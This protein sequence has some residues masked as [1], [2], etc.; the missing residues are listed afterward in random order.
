MKNQNITFYT[1]TVALPDHCILACDVGGTNT[2]CALIEVNGTKQTLVFV[3]RVVTRDVVAFTDV[4]TQALTI[5]REKYNIVV[6]K[7]ACAVAGY[8]VK[9]MDLWRLT[10]VTWTVDK[11]EI[12]KKTMITDVAFLNDFEAI[13]YGLEILP[14]KDLLC[15]NQ[16][17]VNIH[18]PKVVLGAG[19]DLGKCI[20]AWDSISKRY[21]IA[22]SEGAHA[23]FPVYNQEELLLVTFLQKKFKNSMPIRYG[24]ILSGAGISNIY[25]FLEQNGTYASTEYSQ[26]I[27]EHDYDPAIISGYKDVDP[28]SKKTFELFSAF[29]GRSAKNFTVEARAFGGVYLAGGIAAKNTAI[30]ENGI[31]MAEFLNSADLKDLLAQTPIFIITNQDVGLY[32]SAHFAALNFMA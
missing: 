6:T 5:A 30:F 27:K 15:I 14:A 24:K 21:V 18:G 25:Q 1:K 8:P 7:A 26:T 17:T 16:G 22:P 23:D 32:G 3:L 4:I 28:C 29:Y 2:R 31:F 19:T 10:N 12:L 13:G 9:N 20:A 11:K